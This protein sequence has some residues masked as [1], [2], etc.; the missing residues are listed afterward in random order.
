MDFWSETEEAESWSG[1]P[2]TH[3][4]TQKMLEK[5]V[6]TVP[7]LVFVSPS[8]LSVKE[9]KKNRITHP[10]THFHRSISSECTRAEQSLCS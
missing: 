9:G 4:R 1:S 8:L 3:T 6:S 10:K 5:P 7:P 2:H